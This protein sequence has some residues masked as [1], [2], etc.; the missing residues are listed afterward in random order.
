MSSDQAK[1]KQNLHNKI[2][3]AVYPNMK[4]CQIIKSELN[5]GQISCKICQDLEI[6]YN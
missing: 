6:L 1:Y 5:I 2:V 4:L 3:C